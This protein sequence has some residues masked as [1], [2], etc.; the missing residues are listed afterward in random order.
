MKLVLGKHLKYS[1]KN[2]VFFMDD[3][4]FIFSLMAFFAFVV[5]QTVME[6]VTAM[7]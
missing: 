6:I 4:S 2:R 1:F 7:Y 3:Y 5:V